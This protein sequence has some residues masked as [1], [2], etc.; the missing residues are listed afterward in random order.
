MS[1]LEFVEKYR[2]L[3]S[4]ESA[5]QG[6]YSSAPTPFVRAWHDALDSSYVSQVTIVA[7]AQT[8][9]TTFLQNVLMSQIALH[10][11]P[12][13]FM[14]PTL[15]MAK[16]FS[17]GR[18]RAVFNNKVMRGLINKKNHATVN[19]NQIS[20]RGGSLILCGS[21]NIAALSSH[22]I[23]TLYADEIDRLTSDSAEGQPLELAKARTRS[24][25]S[26]KILLT[27]TPTSVKG[28]QIFKEFLNG[29]QEH[30]CYR[31]P[32]CGSYTEPSFERLAEYKYDEQHKTV[33]DEELYM[34]CRNCGSLISETEFRKILMSGEFEWIP[35]APNVIDHRSFW[36][37]GFVSPFV[38]WKEIVIK[39]EQAKNDPNKLR[40]F[41][42]TVLA[43]LYDGLE[44]DKDKAGSLLKARVDFGAGVEVPA[45]VTHL[46]AGVDTQDQYLRYVVYGYGKN[47]GLCCIESGR[48]DGVPSDAETYNRFRAFLARQWKKAD[49]TLINLDLVFVDSQGH[50]AGTWYKYAYDLR[51][52]INPKV[53]IIKGASVDDAPVIKVNFIVQKYLFFGNYARN[54]TTF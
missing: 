30:Y 29:T 49:N 31:C 19:M 36:L 40:V 12:M 34:G 38:P 14:F 8:G 22:P 2:R 44:I 21:N 18:L 13:M 27:S 26:R 6:P 20:F 28:S 46:V 42:N 5:T 15:E 32:D 51:R 53:H 45:A 23:A 17:R 7:P 16:I 54:S 48:I 24:F 4:A 39:Y 37:S 41:K 50:Y 10:P 25:F 33:L 52:N 3:S 35:D 1:S 43:E 11:Q 9:K 47:E